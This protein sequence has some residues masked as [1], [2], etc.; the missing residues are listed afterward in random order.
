MD[1]IKLKDDY[2]PFLFCLFWQQI[3]RRLI[4]MFATCLK[5]TGY[6]PFNS[7]SDDPYLLSLNKLHPFQISS[8]DKID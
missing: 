8:K 1:S 6:L 4:R 2:R 5:K 3:H 7:V